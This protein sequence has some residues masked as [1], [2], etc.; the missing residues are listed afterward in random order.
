MNIRQVIATIVDTWKAANR[1][2]L[3]ARLQ[4]SKDHLTDL[5]SAPTF[6]VG[7]ISIPIDYVEMEIG[8]VRCMDQELG[9]TNQRSEWYKRGN[10]VER[11]KDLFWERESHE[12]LLIIHWKK[13]NVA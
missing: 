13:S 3:P 8:A 4:V 5:G 9:N 7:D 10:N 6:T 11:E 12:L 2:E 1:G